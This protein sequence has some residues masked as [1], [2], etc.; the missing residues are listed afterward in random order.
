[1]QPLTGMLAAGGPEHAVLA[2]SEYW[3]VAGKGGGGGGDATTPGGSH[4]G[5]G[6]AGGGG[7]GHVNIRPTVWPSMPVHVPAMKGQTV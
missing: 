7:K 3:A 4:G 5:G 2:H 1:M 6:A